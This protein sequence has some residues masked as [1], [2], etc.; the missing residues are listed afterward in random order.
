MN[1]LKFIALGAAVAYGVSYLTKRDANGR[2]VVD[3]VLDKAPDL[4]D[5]LKKYGQDALEKAKAKAV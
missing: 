5:N 1:I 3:D 2:S 4:I